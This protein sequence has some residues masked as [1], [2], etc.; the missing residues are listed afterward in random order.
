MPTNYIKKLSK[1]GKGSIADLEKKWDKAKKL[2]SDEDHAEEFDYITGIF[3][4]MIGESYV[5]S[6]KDIL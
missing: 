5:L 1:E 6:T 4:K 2:A 3:K